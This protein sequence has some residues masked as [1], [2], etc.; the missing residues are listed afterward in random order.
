MVGP[1]GQVVFEVPKLGET[2]FKIDQTYAAQEAARRKALEKKPSVANAEKEYYASID[3]L[4][5]VYRQ[6]VQTQFDNVF[7]PAAISYYQTGSQGDL[8]KMEAAAAELNEMITQG[9]AILENA[10]KTYQKGKD[11]GFEEFT[12]NPLEASQSYTNWVNRTGDIVFKDGKVMIRE[13]EG[14]VPVLRSSYYGTEI[15]PNN[16]FMYTPK[17]ELGKYVNPENFVK[18]QSVA[19]NNSATLQDAIDKVTSVYNKRFVNASDVAFAEDVLGS[20]LISPDGLSQDVSPDDLPDLPENRLKI[21]AEKYL[22]LISDY[23]DDEESIESA[24]LLY[25]QKIADLVTKRYN[26]PTPD[27]EKN[28]PSAEWAG[29]AKLIVMEEGVPTVTGSGRSRRVRYDKEEREIARYVGVPP[30]LRGRF[31][32]ADV[33]G[34]SGFSVR[35]KGM[36][37]D[38]NGDLLLLKEIYSGEPGIAFNQFGGAQGGKVFEK[39]T[40]GDWVELPDDVKRIFMEEFSRKRTTKSMDG[41]IIDL[42]ENTYNIP[43]I[44]G[45]R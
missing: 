25:E 33:N 9:T 30:N 6:S 28:R 22:G 29:G 34:L 32:D 44:L 1:L 14:Y 21:S 40:A 39:L 45:I 12:E 17:A 15:N 35:V 16:A 36:A 31:I 23:S 20:Y 5:G 3:K 18:E 7:R 4:K 42:V 11:S 43:E 24:R 13:G 26:E 19:I 8:S 10:G 27:E 37:V 2:G 38:K 41:P